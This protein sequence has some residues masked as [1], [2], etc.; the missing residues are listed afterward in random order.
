MYICMLLGCKYTNISG[1][2]GKNQKMFPLKTERFPESF[3]K[4]RKLSK[5]LSF[6]KK[7]KN[8]GYT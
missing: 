7:T 5:I 6:F 4:F 1:N 2:L 3:P 8:G